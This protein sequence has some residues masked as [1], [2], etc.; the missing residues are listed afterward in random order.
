MVPSRATSSILKAWQAA[1]VAVVL[2]GLLSSP[3]SARFID[4]ECVG[5]M[6][7][8]NIY[9]KV[10][11]VCDDCSNIFRLPNVGESCRKNCFYNEDFLWCVMASERHA[12]VEQFNRWISILKAGRK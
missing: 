12:E 7:N 11:R 4:D 8:R 3:A 10:A 6:G 1:L 5:A 9:D 2:S